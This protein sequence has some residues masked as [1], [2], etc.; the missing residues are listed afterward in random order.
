MISLNLL[1]CTV[2]GVVSADDLLRI[3]S[4]FTGYVKSAHKIALLLKL[5]LEIFSH[6]LS[7]QLYIN[8]LWTP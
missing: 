5:V 3:T 8:V 2:F 7:Y 6:F 4:S 1:F